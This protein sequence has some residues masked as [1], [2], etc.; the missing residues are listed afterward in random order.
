[1]SSMDVKKLLG[2]PKI[3]FVLGK[4]EKFRTQVCEKLVEEYNYTISYT[5]NLL[6]IASQTSNK[7]NYLMNGFPANADQAI[8]FEQN[9][10]ECQKVIY[11]EDQDEHADGE[12]REENDAHSAALQEVIEKYRLF[13]KVR[14]I[15]A[16]QEIE[17]VYRDTKHALLPEVFFLI[18]PKA[19]GKSTVGSHLANKTNMAHMKFDD[20]VKKHN[21]HGSDDETITFELIKTLLDELSPRILLENFPQNLVQAKCFIRNCTEPSRVF[22]CRA[23]KDTCQ[24]RMISLGKDH[25]NYVS[26]AI[27]S[28][29]IKQF[30]EQSP[31]LI[32]FLQ[33]STMFHEIDCDQDL[34]HVKKQIDDLVEPTIIHIR[35]GSNN[36]LKKE[37]IQRL[38]AEHG[39]INLEVNSLI[40]LETERR[41]AVGQEFLQIVQQGK[42]I[43]ADMIVRMLRK[44]IYSGQNHDKFILNGFP[45][46]IEQ[47]NEFEKNCAKISAVF[48]TSQEGENFV[49]IKNNNL[50]LF[51]IDALFQKEFR[52][53]ITDSWDYGRFREMLGSKTDYIIVT[54]TWCSG[55]TTVCQYLASSFGYQIIDHKAVLEE[56][57]KKHE[58][59]EEPPE[60]IPIEEVLEEIAAKIDVMRQTNSK[61]V[62]DTFPGSDP[63]HFDAILDFLGTPDYI[64]VLDSDKEFRKRRYMSKAEAEEWTEELEE[65]TK[66]LPD[67]TGLVVEHCREKYQD[68][69][70]DRFRI[71]EFNLSQDSMKR[72][73]NDEL[74]PKVILINHDKRLASDTTCA[75]LAIKYNLIYISVYQLIRKHIEGN[76]SFGH[77]LLA[78]KKPRAIKINSQ[79]KDEF[80]EADY[81]A[82]HFDLP[83]VLRLIKSTV[84][85]ILSNQKYILLEGLCNSSKLSNESDLL[86]LRPL[87]EL[88]EIERE[89]GEVVAVASLKFSQEKETVEDEEQEYEEFPEPPPQEEKKVEGEG[90]GEQEK[91]PADEGE[92]DQVKEDFKVEEYTWTITNRKPKNLAQVYLQMKEQN[93]VHEIKNAEE[94]SSSQYE[95]ISKS[96]DE[97]ITRFVD[98]DL[99]G[100]NPI[101]Q[102]VFNE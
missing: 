86:E 26:S 85:E 82:I 99:R 10:C 90:E 43:P 15:N 40:R 47:V 35:S 73:I 52:L 66:N 59:D 11:F 57:K 70:P 23:S 19:S 36:D 62:F 13:G 27:L 44:I 81:S 102:I 8:N 7:K 76:T 46:V 20:F 48:L 18:G 38:V 75:N 83:L 3:V 100:K 95:A 96:L 2:N 101:V 72:Q 1:M 93:A 68:I 98:G 53:K 45:D 9:I 77:Q 64:M 54:G 97:F 71:L 4:D 63:A 17:D 88:I 24:E 34:I 65:E 33:E 80:Q 56:C 39:F 50:T 91:P 30:H 94:Y 42:I 6:E 5:D 32:P 89:I 25:P 61:F 79:T 87:D 78:T 22:Y 55:K 14:T 12:H 21:L 29:R 92:G 49:E 51:N 60:S 67:N 41:T 28:K 58:N 37:M 31:T 74:C 16:S 69:S 84:N